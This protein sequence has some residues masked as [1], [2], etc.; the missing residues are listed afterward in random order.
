MLLDTDKIKQLMELIHDT[1]I[2]NVEVRDGEQSIRLERF[3]QKTEAT[4][5]TTAAAAA[6]A[7][8]SAQI[9]ATPEAHQHTIKSPMVGIVY[10]APTPNSAN[11]VE[12]G[13]SVKKGQVVCIIEAM[14]MMN[15]I[16]ADCN[17]TIKARLV[18]N[19]HSVEF[20]QPLFII[21]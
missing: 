4:I 12:V 3:S 13:Q 15:Q 7:P 19:G 10:H 20:D 17:G 16:E 5:T 1:D 6:P 8:L 18:D 14:K 9:A 2:C 11:F 21:E